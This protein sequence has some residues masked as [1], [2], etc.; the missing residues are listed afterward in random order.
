MCDGIYMQYRF[1]LLDSYSPRAPMLIPD[2]SLR[3]ELRKP[4][5]I[6]RSLYHF[7]WELVGVE[8]VVESESLR[9]QLHLNHS[10]LLCLIC[11]T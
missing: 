8:V 11:P 6:T 5:L 4:T 3:D 2:A 9:N 7:S 10:V 1:T